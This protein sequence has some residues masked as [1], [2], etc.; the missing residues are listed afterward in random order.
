MLQLET[1]TGFANVGE[2]GQEVN[3]DDV[4]RTIRS[5]IHSAA[6]DDREAITFC[7]VAF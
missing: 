5:A 3:N 6:K 4:K 7:R 1:A 2:Q